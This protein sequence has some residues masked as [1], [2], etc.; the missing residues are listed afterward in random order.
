MTKR[1]EVAKGAYV[2]RE[3]SKAELT[4]V[5]VG[6][7]FSI[8]VDVVEALAKE[9]IK[10]RLVSFPCQRLFERQSVGYRR[11]V[12]QRHIRP[13]VVI[14][15]YASC[16]WERYAD[17]AVCMKLERFGKSLP[18]KD[19]YRYFGFVPEKIVPKVKKWLGN[20]QSGHVLPSEF[21]EL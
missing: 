3:E 21:V 11:S 19:A 12:L 16:G 10:T 18:G 15:A 17:A 14:E 1:Y 9:G 5:G 2:V 6:A 20:R 8:A 4:I 7:E 13:V